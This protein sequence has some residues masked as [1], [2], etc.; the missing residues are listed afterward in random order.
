MIQ[1]AQTKPVFDVTLPAAAVQE[2]RRFSNP[3]RN[4]PF[5]ADIQVHVF[6]SAAFRRSIRHSISADPPHSTASPHRSPHRS[7]TAQPHHCSK[8]VPEKAAAFSSL[9]IKGTRSPSRQYPASRT[10]TLKGNRSPDRIPRE[11]ALLRKSAKFAIH[12]IARVTQN[13]PLIAAQRRKSTHTQ[14]PSTQEC[15]QIRKSHAESLQLL[16]IIP[17]NT[18]ISTNTSTRPIKPE[19]FV[20]F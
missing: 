11:P 12:K 8:T 19:H 3:L 7:V 4:P 16:N 20:A 1:F 9:A 17:L 10:R 15:H 5:S 13:Y 18:S 6:Q 14:G 2:V